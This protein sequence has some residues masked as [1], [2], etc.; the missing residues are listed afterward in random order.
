MLKAEGLGEPAVD[1]SGF[2]FLELLTDSLPLVHKWKYHS[3][4]N[5]GKD[6]GTGGALI[7]SPSI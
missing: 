1:L 6:K 4:G 3:A 7:D 5:K 2:V